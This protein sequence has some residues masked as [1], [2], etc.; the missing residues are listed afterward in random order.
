[1]KKPFFWF[2]LSGLAVVSAWLYLT[3]PQISPEVLDTQLRGISPNTVVDVRTDREYRSSRIPTSV[4]VPH[5]GVWMKAEEILPDKQQPLVVY[6]A[7]GPR[8]YIAYAQFKWMG[9]DNVR[10]LSGHMRR[11][12]N[13]Q[14]PTTSGPVINPQ[15][16]KNERND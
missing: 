11:W 13:E 10:V 3:A 9:Y 1:M 14:R 8:A 2:F 15:E 6:C 4:T 16:T 5:W 7:H 12:E